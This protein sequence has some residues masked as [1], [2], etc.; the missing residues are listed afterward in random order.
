MVGSDCSIYGCSNSTNKTKGLGIFRIPT[1]D[2][3][4][5]K[6]WRNA[7]LQIITKDRVVGNQLREQI[8]KR[9]YVFVSYTTEKIKSIVVSF[10]SLILIITIANN[11]KDLLLYGS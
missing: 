2:D 11:Y 5:R 6:N 7:L 4:Y 1:K 3:E 10:L 8:A 9:S